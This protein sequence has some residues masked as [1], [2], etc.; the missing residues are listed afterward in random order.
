MGKGWKSRNNGKDQYG[1]QE[2]KWGYWRGARASYSPSQKQESWRADREQGPTFPKYDSRWVD[3]RQQDPLLVE[4]STRTKASGSR[5]LA[6]DLQVVI[7]QARKLENKLSALEENRKRRMAQWQQYQVDLQKSF[8]EEKERYQR[9]I[10]KLES[11]IATV[12]EQC[13]TA[14]DQLVQAAQASGVA[15]ETAR[16]M[17]GIDDEDWQHLTGELSLESSRVDSLEDDILLARAI[18]RRRAMLAPAT[19]APEPEVNLAMQGDGRQRAASV[20]APTMIPDANGSEEQNRLNHGYAAASPDI[21]RRRAAPYPPTSP[22]L[23]KLS[24]EAVREAVEAKDA[25]P[26]T[27][28]R[29]SSRPRPP[30]GSRQNI[31]DSSKK[32]PARVDTGLSLEQKLEQKRAAESGA[33]MRPFRQALSRPPE[34]TIDAHPP[35]FGE[36]IND[37]LEDEINPV[38][39]GFTNME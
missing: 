21:A 3:L 1:G 31:K 17:E 7:N 22:T 24:G 11:D 37:D 32:P 2:A 25:P 18:R 27:E 5:S 29:E 28:A 38:S 34:D 9:A 39:P 12:Q 6:N 36:I 33:A 30:P 15:V 8:R 23:T 19:R 16:G 14:Q 20:V 26:S 4:V 35:G 13:T 10:S